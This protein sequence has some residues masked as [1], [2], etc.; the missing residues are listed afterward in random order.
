MAAYEG[1]KKLH[2]HMNDRIEDM[3]ADMNDDTKE[4]ILKLMD[5]LEEELS[6]IG[7]S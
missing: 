5:A 6:L 3:I 7:D 1:H 4:E 2:K